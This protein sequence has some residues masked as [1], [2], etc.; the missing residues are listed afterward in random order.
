M[1]VARSTEEDGVPGPLYIGFDAA[2]MKRL[3][4]LRPL[5][6]DRA[7][8][9]QMGTGPGVVF[10]HAPSDL[11]ILARLE[12]VG[13]APPGSTLIE[14]VVLLAMMAVP[15]IRVKGR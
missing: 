13:A 14:A 1:I 8:S 4:G 3:Q 15:K 5:V 12:Y 9:E 11:A 10:F 7:G 2:D 6:L